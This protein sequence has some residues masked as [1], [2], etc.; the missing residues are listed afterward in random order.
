MPYRLNPHN[1]KEVQARKGGRWISL[2]VH[3]TPGQA[4]KHLRD[5]KTKVVDGT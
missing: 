4:A 2:K 3:L 5:L 1:K